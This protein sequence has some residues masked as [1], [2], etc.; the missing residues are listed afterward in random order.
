MTL[1]IDIL[2]EKKHRIHKEDGTQ[3]YR[4]NQWVHVEK[5]RGA[6]KGKSMDVGR[7]VS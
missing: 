6:D 4:G 5:A 1:G 7:P 2:T 3:D